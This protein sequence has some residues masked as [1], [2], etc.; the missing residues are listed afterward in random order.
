MPGECNIQVA[1]WSFP[2]R[3]TS[4]SPEGETDA[5]LLPHICFLV[6]YDAT[7]PCM[8]LSPD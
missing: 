3:K 5:Q 2:R 8:R 7:V 4:V 1:P 6:V